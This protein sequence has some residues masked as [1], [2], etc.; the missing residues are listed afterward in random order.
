MPYRMVRQQHLP[1]AIERGEV[2]WADVDRSVERV[3]A[4]KNGIS[5]FWA[6]NTA[7]GI[8]H[9]RDVEVTDCEFSYCNRPVFNP[10]GCGLDLEGGGNRDIAVR[11]CRMAL[12]HGAGLMLY[13]KGGGNRDVHI[14]GCTFDQNCANQ[15]K[16]AGF[17]VVVLGHHEG[18]RLSGNKFRPRPGIAALMNGNGTVTDGNETL[19]YELNQRSEIF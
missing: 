6:G 14:E 16:P 8:E 2:S 5:E 10:D 18:L 4:T 19:T 9:C 3:I 17:E 1:A 11:N 13:D 7:A 12:N 15:L